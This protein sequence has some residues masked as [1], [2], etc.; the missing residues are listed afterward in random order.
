MSRYFSHINSSKKILE[1]YDG[2]QPFPLHLKKHFAA[3]KN[4][5]SKDR[6]TIGEICYAWLRTSHLFAQKINDE[7]II[8]S[9]FLCADT[10]HPLLEALAPA[11]NEKAGLPAAGKLSFL[12]LSIAGIF[13][14]ME[15]CGVDDKNEFNLSFLRQP[16]LFLRLRPGR[17]NIVLSGLRTAAVSFMEMDNDC[18]GLPNG[19]KLGE[20][21]TLNKEAVVQDKNSQKVFDFLKDQSFDE[22][23]S[24]WDCCAASGGKSILLYDILKGKIKLT[25]SDIRAGILHNC[26][27]RLREAGININHA[28]VADVSKKTDPGESF[29]IIICDAPC[30]GSG[31]WSRTPEQLAFFKKEKINEFSV[32]QKNIAANTSACL[33]KSGLFFYITCS[34]FKKEN[35]EVVD[36]LLQT[37][38]LE[39]LHSTYLPGYGEQADTMYLAVLR[40]NG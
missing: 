35:E 28:F 3:N 38:D 6:K 37:T 32:L 25:V 33:K 8:H 36:T 16:L 31:T 13:P 11:L 40:R 10:T 9:F 7:N 20:L 5:G 29:D 18:V 34:V 12:Q 39:L 4:A 22:K 26:K 17:Q 14:F 2:L 24:V 15:E 1:T 30:T 19:T 21:I 27:T 23:I